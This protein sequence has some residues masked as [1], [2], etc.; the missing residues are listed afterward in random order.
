MIR[1][2]SPSP[3]QPITRKNGSGSD[4]NYFLTCFTKH[5]KTCSA[6]TSTIIQFVFYQK[7]FIKYQLISINFLNIHLI[8]YLNIIKYCVDSHLILIIDL[9]D[10]LP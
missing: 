7:L 9:M 10:Y 6:G 4:W 8:H 5:S 3:L 2:M 1:L